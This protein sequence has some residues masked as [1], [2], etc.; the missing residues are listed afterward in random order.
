[1]FQ[2][3]PVLPGMRCLINPSANGFFQ[4]PKPKTVVENFGRADG[5]PIGSGERPDPRSCVVNW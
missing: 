1:M 2:L 4:I 3:V 5:C